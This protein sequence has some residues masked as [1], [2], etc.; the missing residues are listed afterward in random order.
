MPSHHHMVAPRDPDGPTDIEGGLRRAHPRPALAP[1]RASGRSASSRARMPAPRSSRAGGRR[2]APVTRYHPGPVPADSRVAS[3]PYD[4]DVP[5]EVQV[6]RQRAAPAATPA[7]PTGCASRS[8]AASTS[9]ACC[10][11][12]RR[13]RDY[14]GHV[15]RCL[16]RAAARGG[17]ARRARPRDG[18]LRRPRRRSGARRPA[19]ARRARRS[20]EAAHRPRSRHRSRAT[21]AEV[22]AACLEWIALDRR[23]LQRAGATGQ[24]PGRRSGW[25]TP[26]RWRRGSAKTPS[27]SAR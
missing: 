5:L 13:R 14:C 10:G 11:S 23:A 22:E 9:C 15:R 27:A 17:S 16:C 7:P 12:R 26:S 18:S 6:E 24:A 19:T 3:G 25:N 4:P 21:C 1:R 8:R 2:V 20:G